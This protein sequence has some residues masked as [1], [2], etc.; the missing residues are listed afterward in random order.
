MTEKE[1]TILKG[2]YNDA[3]RSSDF[4]RTKQKTL[5][6]YDL[7]VAK[8][9]EIEYRDRVF[10]LGTFA[11]RIGLGVELLIWEREDWD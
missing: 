4:W 9:A 1:I 2:M 3:R 6:G 5:N 10:I 7:E 11:H 8:K